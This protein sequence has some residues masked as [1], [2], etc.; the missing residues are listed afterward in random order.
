MRKIIFC[1]LLSFSLCACTTYKYVITPVKT[2]TENSYFK[3]DIKFIAKGKPNL[4]NGILLSVH[5]K[6]D[7]DI[8]LVWDKTLYIKDGQ[9]SGG[10][11]FEG[12]VYK[13]RNET[14]QNDIIFA[15]SNFQKVIYPNNLVIMTDSAAMAS[16]LGCGSVY[17]QSR[18]W[19]HD[20]FR[21]GIHGIYLTLKVEEK[22]IHE[23][24]TYQLNHV[25]E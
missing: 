18:Q 2:G 4:L 20:T 10:F 15:N 19:C 24:I 14:K 11:M 22:V 6:T 21:K 9:T 7:K 5:N 23:T 8:E 1:V 16:V 25:K 17:G 13:D 3:A 12:V